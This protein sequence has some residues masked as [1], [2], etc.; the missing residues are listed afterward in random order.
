MSTET[1]SMI[2]SE[3]ATLEA[4]HKEELKE[5]RTTVRFV[6]DQ[7]ISFIWSVYWKIQT[8]EIRVAVNSEDLYDAHIETALK[9]I[10]K[11]YK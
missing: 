3:F 1:Y 9:K 7:F 8:E 10:M 2:A 6:K 5:Y 11:E 4:A